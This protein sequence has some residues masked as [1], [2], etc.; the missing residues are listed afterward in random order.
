MKYIGKQRACRIRAR[1]S[2]DSRKDGRIYIRDPV[3]GAALVRS[4]VNDF[5]A[6]GIRVKQPHINIGRQRD[7]AESLC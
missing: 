5:L 1:R 6:Q 7:A 4:I 3:G 2:R